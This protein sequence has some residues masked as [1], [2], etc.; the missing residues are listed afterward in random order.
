V[1]HNEKE[2][3]AL[4]TPIQ[5]T[6]WK[7]TAPNGHEEYVYTPIPGFEHLFKVPST[8]Q[9]APN[10][11]CPADAHYLAAQPQHVQA[12]GKTTPLCIIG[13]PLTNCRRDSPPGCDPQR[14]S[15]SSQQELPR[16]QNQL[17]EKGSSEACKAERI[18]EDPL[19]GAGT[20]TAVQCAGG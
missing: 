6:P 15:P 18:E 12:P 7:I 14:H 20:I 5:G 9:G 17:E 11:G 1:V 19:G 10:T 16:N 8:S 3:V 2:N 13:R 4:P